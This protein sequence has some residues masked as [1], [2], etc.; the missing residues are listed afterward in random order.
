M[1]V[2]LL[3]T[4]PFPA[5]APKVPMSVPLRVRC[6]CRLIGGFRIRAARPEHGACHLSAYCEGAPIATSRTGEPASHCARSGKMIVHDNPHLV[7]GERSEIR[8][9]DLARLGRLAW[10]IAN[11]GPSGAPGGGGALPC[12]KPS[13]WFSTL[14][15]KLTGYTATMAERQLPILNFRIPLFQATPS[16]PAWADAG[17][18]Q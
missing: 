9:L 1:G 7:L 11:G 2:T 15:F 13:S 18:R 5:S 12:R 3:G 4:S 6:R 16:R 8:V 17:F 14:A 10:W